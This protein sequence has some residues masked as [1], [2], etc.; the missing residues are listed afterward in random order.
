MAVRLSY[1]FPKA[2]S[3]LKYEKENE[4]LKIQNKWENVFF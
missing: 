1:P 3:N 2:S 4:T